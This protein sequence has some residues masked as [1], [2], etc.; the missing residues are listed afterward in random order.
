MDPGVSCCTTVEARARKNKKIIT[1]LAQNRTKNKKKKPTTKS[2]ISGDTLCEILFIVIFS[3]YFATRTPWPLV[4]F[5]RKSLRLRLTRYLR[6]RIV[7]AY[8]TRKCYLKS[9]QNATSCVLYH[10]MYIHY[11]NIIISVLLY[12]GCH[13]GFQ[14]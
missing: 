10:F 5:F 3:L 1:H 11:I 7:I 12:E 14:Q 6:I 4:F 8:V 9:K 2:N 13:I